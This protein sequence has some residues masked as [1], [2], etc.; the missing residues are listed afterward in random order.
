LLRV[1]AEGEFYRVGGQTPVKVD[2]R[3]IAATHQN[4]EERVER[5]I[6]ARISITAS[7]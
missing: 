3:V 4:L 1:L 7:T 6:F 5:G 2:V